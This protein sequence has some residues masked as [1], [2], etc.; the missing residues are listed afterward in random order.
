MPQGLQLFREDGSLQLDSNIKVPVFLRKGSISPTEIIPGGPS[1]AT[2]SLAAGELLA[3]R[4]ASPAIL[5]VKRSGSVDIHSTGGSANQ[6][7]YYVF[8][9]QSVSPS[10]GLQ[11]FDA[12][13]AKVY[14]ATQKPLNIVGILDDATSSL[15]LPSGTYAALQEAVSMS[16]TRISLPP[17]PA[18]ATSLEANLTATGCQIHPS[19]GE[20]SKGVGLVDRKI[21]SGSF[22]SFQRN[23]WDG[24]SKS[25]GLTSKFFIA[26]VTGF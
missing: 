22:T 21:Y 9:F 25:N 14:D 2:V 12:S 3:F 13:G 6:I 23:Q 11:V 26:N 20:V 7:H 18:Q 16:D 4:C 15:D 19:S 1:K 8:G 5:N 10:F 17:P 24:S